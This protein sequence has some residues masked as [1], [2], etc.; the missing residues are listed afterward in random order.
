MDR[1]NRLSRTMRAFLWLA[2]LS[3]VA[4][5]MGCGGGKSGGKVSGTVKYQGTPLPSGT[6][7]FFD[8]KKQIVG[9]ATIQNGSYTME[10]VPPG[11][12]MVSVT[13]PPA[14]M[15][16]PNH[17]PPRGRPDATPLPVVPIPAQYGNPEQSGLTYDVNPGTQDFPIELR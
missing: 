7:T 4:A 14:V 16:N 11:K 2:V 8:A 9:S 12:M 10:G 3:L 1:H 6:V 15:P 13:T 17:P 5:G